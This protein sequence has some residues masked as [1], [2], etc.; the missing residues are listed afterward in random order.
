LATPWVGELTDLNLLAVRDVAMDLRDAAQLSDCPAIPI[1]PTIVR[2]QELMPVQTPVTMD[3]YGEIRGAALKLLERHGVVRDVKSL[4]DPYAHR[5]QGKMTCQVD[6]PTLDTVVVD[7]KA[8]HQRR[9]DKRAA[10]KAG[11]SPTASD[12]LS[13]LLQQLLRFHAVAL[14]LRVRYS[15]RPVLELGDEYDVQYLLGALL[16]LHFEDVRREEWTPSYAGGASRVDFLLKH[17]QIV[18]EVKKTRDGLN[19][20]KLG[21]ELI[22]DIA[23]YSAHPDCKTLVCFVYDPDHRIANPRGLEADLGGKRNGLIV[24]VLVIPKR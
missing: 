2:F 5:W 16:N 18:V 17:E 21:D 15:G 12:A 1:I 23:H 13:V 22:L 8:E 20:R 6:S 7:L 9:I 24:Q 4:H 19:D 11:V 3:R 10:T 14:A